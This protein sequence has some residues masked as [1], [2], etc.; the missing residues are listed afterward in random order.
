MCI[1][2]NAVLKRLIE[3]RKRLS[4]SQKDMAQ[5]VHMSQ[6]NYS[7]VEKGLRRLDFYELKYL[8]EADVDIHY[9]YTAQRSLQQF[10]ISFEQ[11][12]RFEY[13]YYLGILFII[14]LYCYN[15][16]GI[17]EWDY[18]LVKLKY[19]S[20]INKRCDNENIF[21]TLRRNLNFQQ[22]RMADILGVDVK[23]YR[24]LEKGRKLPDSELLCRL[25]ATYNIPPS[26]F[27]QD[28][29]CILNEIAILL[30]MM[31]EKSRMIVNDIIMKI[32][33]NE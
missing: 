17:K 32:I 10:K 15:R 12:S 13:Q 30:E 21:V 8:C 1:T 33:S 19:L 6:S 18:I 4:L 20:M 16:K 22:K 29:K 28:K 25:Y 5:Y 9:V 7:K 3:E 27:L 24:D 14:E 26:V 11:Y 2:Y 23:K 31:D